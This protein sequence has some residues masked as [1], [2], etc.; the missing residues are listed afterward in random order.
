MCILDC[1]RSMS[2]LSCSRTCNPSSRV[3][4]PM[5]VSCAGWPEGIHTPSTPRAVLLRFGKPIM[6]PQKGGCHLGSPTSAAASTWVPGGTPD[7][8]QPALLQRDGFVAGPSSGPW[9]SHPGRRAAPPLP[10]PA[11][12]DAE[13]E[14]L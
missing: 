7:V 2:F 3:P 8:N 1:G 10:A 9:E 4:Y 11:T 6:Q 13:Y 14:P 5:S 12:G